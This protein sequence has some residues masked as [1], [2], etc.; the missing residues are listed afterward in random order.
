[1]IKKIWFKILN[2]FRKKK[3]KKKFYGDDPFI[4]D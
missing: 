3:K 4:Y 2:F 1:M